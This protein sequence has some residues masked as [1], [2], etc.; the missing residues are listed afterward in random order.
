MIESDPLFPVLDADDTPT[1]LQTRKQVLKNRS[2]K[3]LKAML[4]K[5]HIM[6]RVGR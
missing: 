5:V 4:P 1:L 6:P 2:Y 3:A